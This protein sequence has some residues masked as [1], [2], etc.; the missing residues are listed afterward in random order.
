M[1]VPDQ[2]TPL[3]LLG[4]RRK[5]PCCRARQTGHELTPSHLASPPYAARRTE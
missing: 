4:T 3:R 1:K 2:S 5:R